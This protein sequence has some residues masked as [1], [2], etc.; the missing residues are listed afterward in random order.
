MTP[1]ISVDEL[2]RLDAPVILSA[3]MGPNPPTDGIP[4]AFL[5]DL[6]ADFSEPGHPLPHTVPAD[7]ARVFESYGIS[8]DTAVV[9]YD[10]QQ[11]ATAPRVWWLALV[12]GL[13]D[14]RVLDG[15]WAG[16]GHHC[17]GPRATAPSPP[18]PAPVCLSTPP[19]S[20]P[21]PASWWT[22]ARRDV[23]PAPNPSPARA[24][25]PGVPRGR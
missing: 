4:G 16:S 5:A 1:L 23:S 21:A 12:A 9:V 11:G 17:P 25:A 14:V 20:P 13:T 10:D 22:P 2:T 8:D 18:H 7:P 3:S 6:E 15:P 24:C 19:P